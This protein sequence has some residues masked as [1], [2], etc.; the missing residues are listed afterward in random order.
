MAGAVGHAGSSPLS[1]LASCNRYGVRDGTEGTVDC[2]LWTVD[3][4]LRTVDCGSWTVDC[5]SWT[6]DRGLWTVEW[7]IAE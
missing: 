4:G 2:G 6:V 7:Q 3:C 1:R 5:G